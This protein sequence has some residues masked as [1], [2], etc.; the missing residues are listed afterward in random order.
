M[1]SYSFTMT[2]QELIW[3]RIAVHDAITSKE[4]EIRELVDLKEIGKMDEKQVDT[5]LEQLGELYHDLRKFNNALNVLKRDHRE[6]G[7]LDE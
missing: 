1:E 6:G 7:G 5:T 4:G 2:Y 3:A